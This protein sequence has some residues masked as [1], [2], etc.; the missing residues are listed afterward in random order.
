MVLVLLLIMTVLFVFSTSADTTDSS[1]LYYGDVDMDGRVT[2]KDATTVQ[3]G[4]AGIVY[5]TSVQRFLAEPETYEVTVKTATEIQKYLT[6]IN[7]TNEKLGD[8]V[9][10]S[11]DNIFSSSIS[12][13]HRYLDDCI[14]VATKVGFPHNYRL[15][16]FPEYDFSDIRLLGDPADDMN[17]FYVLSLEIPGKDNV[18]EAVKALDYRAS[19]DLAAV[20]PN[21]I[22]TID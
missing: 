1:A 17:A 13:K 4:V 9:E 19:I 18:I 21:Y 12:S 8:F 3:K 7:V 6:G 14:I 11:E 5:L 22:Y 15:E 2:I 20:N 16:D 10:K